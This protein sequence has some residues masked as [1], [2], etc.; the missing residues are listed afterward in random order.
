MIPGLI[1]KTELIVR[2][3]DLVNRL[4]DIPVEVLSTPRLVQLLE[5][6]SLQAIQEYLPADRLCLG[7]QVKI[8][9]LSATPLGMRVT[10]HALLK[11]VNQNRLLFLVDAYDER[12]KVAEGEHERIIVS[13]ERF[14]QKMEEKIKLFKK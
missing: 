11:E 6:A 12:E 13:R 8:K 3:E 2:E 4:G 7:T 1:G 9:H 5:E 14:F 10:A